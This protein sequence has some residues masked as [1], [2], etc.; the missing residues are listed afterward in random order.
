MPTRAE[1]ELDIFSGMPNP[2]WTLTAAE[3]EGLVKRLDQ[4]APTPAKE[5]CQAA[6]VIAGSSSNFIRGNSRLCSAFRTVLFRFLKRPRSA[7]SSTKAARWNV[8]CLTRV[9]LTS[10]PKS[11]KSPSARC[12]DFTWSGPVARTSVPAFQLGNLQKQVRQFAGR[13]QHR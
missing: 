3:A 1:V 4:L 5:N 12:I 10:R 7:M 2:S 8:G 6:W 11:R 9:Y 13:S